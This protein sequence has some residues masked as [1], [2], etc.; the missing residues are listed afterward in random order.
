MKTV[1]GRYFITSIFAAGAAM[2]SA[3]PVFADDSGATA[4]DATCT[5]CHS[6]DDIARWAD[7]YPDTET[8][9]EHYDSFLETHHA[10]DTNSRAAIIAYMEETLTA[11][12]DDD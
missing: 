3:A 6:V 10:P 2:V 11:G 1:I 12:T 4:F 7:R 9:I 5:T 8:R